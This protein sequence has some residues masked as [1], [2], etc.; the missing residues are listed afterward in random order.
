LSVPVD[1]KVAEG[2][3]L[4]FSISEDTGIGFSTGNLIPYC[5]LEYETSSKGMDDGTVLLEQGSGQNSP[6]GLDGR[7]SPVQVRKGKAVKFFS[8]V[9]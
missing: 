5:H 8:T 1:A 9:V 4:G 3:M 7:T 6:R 2:D